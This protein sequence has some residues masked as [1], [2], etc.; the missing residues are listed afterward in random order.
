MK[1]W[2]TEIGLMIGQVLDVLFPEHSE[3]KKT[4]IHLRFFQKCNT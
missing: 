2:E 3:Q 4:K 1:R